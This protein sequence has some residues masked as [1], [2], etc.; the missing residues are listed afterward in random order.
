[1]TDPHIDS[2][3]LKH[4]KIRGMSA[5]RD[6]LSS[7]SH[8]K[9]FALARNDYLRSRVMVISAIFLLLLPFWT[10]LDW[11]ML[12]PESLHYTLPGRF[13][14]AV[15]LVLVFLLARGSKA[16]LEWARISAGLLLATPAAFYALVLVSLPEGQYSLIGYSF[17]PY[18]L[19]AMLAIFP[20]TLL[21][22]AVL[23]LALILLQA[24]ALF[25][26]G[27]LLTAAGLQEIW[28]LA[29]LLVIA[30]TANYFQLGLMLRLYR[31]ATHDP[32]T[33]LLNRGALMRTME[34]MTN[35]EHT[36]PLA[37]L[38]MDLDHFKR[39]NDT[40]G[41]AFGDDVLRDFAGVLRRSLRPVD[42]A[43]RYGGEEFTAVLNGADKDTALHIAERIRQQ[44]E[45]TVLL[46]Y[47]GEPV[48]Y[49]VSIGAASLHPGERFET[50]ARRADNRLYEAKKISR[51]RVV[52]V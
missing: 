20:F 4:L 52:G 47:D 49:T 9:D 28:L 44:A 21:E 45:D 5:V 6:A 19:T 41:H 14:M 46:N 22:S 7:R 35:D 23:G 33:G 2:L 40:H 31:E 36:Q 3:N 29:A 10:M 25:L 13:V 34:Q 16:H 48:R 17:I 32:L 8:S 37:L 24:Y 39:V 43:A 11:F 18:M 50:A 1:M 51:N 26:V 38:M 12:P 42:I 15:L 30:L 27:N